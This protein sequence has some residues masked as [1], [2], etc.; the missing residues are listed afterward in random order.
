MTKLSGIC[1]V[2]LYVYVF[3]QLVRQD[4]EELKEDVRDL[5]VIMHEHMALSGDPQ[6]DVVQ[7]CEQGRLSED[8]CSV[9]A[10]LKVP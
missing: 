6:V 10:G 1:L 8:E 5:R 4:V 3:V 7:L 2:L 9:F